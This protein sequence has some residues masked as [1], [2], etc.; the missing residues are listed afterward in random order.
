MVEAGESAQPVYFLQKRKRR[1]K[2]MNISIHR[3]VRIEKTKPIEQTTDQGS[4]FVSRQIKITSLNLSGQ[5]ESVTIV[6]FASASKLLKLLP[7][8]EGPL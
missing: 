3:V 7:N 8:S 6:L 2:Q 1:E 5:E 4:K